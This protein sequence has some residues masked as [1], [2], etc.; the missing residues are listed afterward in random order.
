[1]THEEVV[2]DLT[3]DL[4]R[5]Y[6]QL[7]MIVYHFQTKFRDE[8]RAR[9]GLIRVRE[10]VMKDSYTLDRDWAGLDESYQKHY[11]A[12]S[13]IFERLGLDAIPVSSDVG[14]MGGTEAHEFMVLNPYGEDTL[15]VCEACGYAANQQIAPTV[16][17]A[18]EAEDA[19]ARSRRSPRPTRPRSRRWRPS[20]ASRQS[21]TAKAAFFVAGDGRF[22]VAIVRGD[23]DVNETKLV[24]AL[25]V[26]R[27]A[28][29]GAG[30]GDHGARDAARLRL[31]DRRARRGRR[32]RQHRGRLARTSSPGRTSP[33][34]HLRNTNV[35]RDYTPDVIADIA[36]V[37]EGD[38]CPSCGGA[39]HAPQGH[40]GRQHLQARDE[41]HGGARRRVPGRGR[42]AAPDGDGL[43]R[44]RARPQRRVHRR[45][46]PRREGHRLAARGRALRR[47]SR[48]ARRLEGAPGAARSRIGSTTWRHPRVRATRSCTTIATSRPA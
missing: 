14:M 24:N 28:A 7:P 43:V 3:R 48:G 4:V 1:M 15:V 19:A 13:R 12:Y 2:A 46:A 11:E 10:F 20:W 47:A 21:R 32:G 9:G 27:R 6:R 33:A 34:V 25:K 37:R 22:V 30:R 41:V 18:I 42:R 16:A 36:N 44:H 38:P 23:Y 35:P 29:P 40:R 5:S 17:P 31:A 26:D 45:G 39:D 8:P